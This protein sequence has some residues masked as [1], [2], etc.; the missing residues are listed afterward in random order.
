[1]LNRSPRKERIATLA[2]YQEMERRVGTEHI[3]PAGGNV[4]LDLGFSP[5]VAAKLKAETVAIIRA[6][7]T[8]DEQEGPVGPSLHPI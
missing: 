1:M 3:T 5:E 6:K 4:F 8:T 2:R 7:L